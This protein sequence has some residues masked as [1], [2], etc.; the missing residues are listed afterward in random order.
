[1]DIDIYVSVARN[2]QC[3]FHF[4]A[5]T[6]CNGQ[7]SQQQ[8]DIGGAVGGADLHGLLAFRWNG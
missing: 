1:M 3:V 5:M 8:I 2:V 6:A 7:G 4:P